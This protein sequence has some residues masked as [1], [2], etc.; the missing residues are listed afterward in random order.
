MGLWAQLWVW[1]RIPIVA[2]LTS[3]LGLFLA[4]ELEVR[5]L[6]MIFMIPLFLAFSAA[7][8][9]FVC[10]ACLSSLDA[11]LHNRS[12]GFRRIVSMGASSAPLLAVIFAVGYLVYVVIR[13]VVLSR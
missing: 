4:D 8:G 1:M 2:V 10:L 7:F 6:R 11:A 12:R 9:L 5:I 13:A 3:A